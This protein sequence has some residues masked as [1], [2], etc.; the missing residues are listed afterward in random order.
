[1]ASAERSLVMEVSAEQLF[2]VVTDFARYPE[3]IPE[4]K[5]ARVLES[6]GPT[7]QVEFELELTLLGFVRR[8]R[9]TLGFE[10]K[11]P[12]AVDWHFVGGE[13]MKD[14]RGGW[15]LKPLGPTRT[16]A[17]YRIEVELGAFI[18]R[19]VSRFLTEQSLPKLLEQ[20]KA[21]AESLSKP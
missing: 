15:L 1:M 18:P 8:I 5:A 3:F 20:F 21:R 14:N 7:R 19:S 9:Y 2:G 17:T 11:P 10:L 12:T 6:Q 4:L 16:E 13:V